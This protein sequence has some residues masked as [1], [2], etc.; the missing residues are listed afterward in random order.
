MRRLLTLSLEH[1]L[2]WVRLYIHPIGDR[3]AAMIV[4]DDVPLPG[5]DEIL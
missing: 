1:E 2:L 5:Q 4:R 3:W